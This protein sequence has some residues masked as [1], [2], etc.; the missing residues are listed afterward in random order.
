[1]GRILDI[2]TA[3]KSGTE[4]MDDNY[5]NDKNNVRIYICMGIYRIGALS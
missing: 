2:E 3:Y 1:M 4:P 5:T